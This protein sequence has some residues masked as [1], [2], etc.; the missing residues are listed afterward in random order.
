MNILQGGEERRKNE[1]IVNFYI[2]TY[3]REKVLDSIFWTIII[4]V[5]QL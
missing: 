5:K 3:M 2:V 4:A 1:N